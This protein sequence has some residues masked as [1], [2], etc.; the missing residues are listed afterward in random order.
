MC[1]QGLGFNLDGDPN[2]PMNPTGVTETALPVG[3]TYRMLT[4][5]WGDDVVALGLPLSP[6]VAQ[7]TTLGVFPGPE[8]GPGFS[9][10]ATFLE[11][12]QYERVISPDAPFDGIFPPEVSTVQIT[13]VVA[14]PEQDVVD[15]IDVTSEIPGAGPTIPTFD[16]TRVQR[17]DEWT[18]YL[19]DTTTK[20][21]L[22][23]VRSLSGT[24]ANVVLATN[25]TG[26][27]PMIDALTN[28]E[29][30]LAPPVGAPIPTSVF[31]P[32]GQELPAQLTYPPLPQPVTLTGNIV[33][34]D[35]TPIAADLVFEAL[36]ITDQNGLN[37]A[38]FEFVGAASARPTMSGASAYSVVLPP[39]QYRVDLRPAGGTGAVTVTSLLVGPSATSTTQ[40]FTV[41]A[42]RPLEGLARVAD[43][44]LLSGAIVEAVGTQC[45]TPAALADG[46]ATALLSVQAS[47]WCLPQSSQTTTAADGSFRLQLDPGSYLV[48]V[49]P[50]D[51]TRLPW[52]SKT[53]SVAGTAPGVTFTVPAPLSASVQLLDPA[54]IPIVNAV[55]RA[56]AVPSPSSSV[57]SPPAPA[58]EVGRAITDSTGTYEMY[59]SL[60]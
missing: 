5:F 7:P 45:F 44:R 12:A 52:V 10:Q 54:D 24:T 60:P 19:R 41:E 11:P 42:P 53:V 22:S 37:N 35:G 57:S 15:S 8:G 25:H 32:A 26:H 16:I 30:V 33:S 14:R 46:G 31:I 40:D 4:D 39:G 23:N 51:G 1:A 49:R 18:A 9:F 47:T 55:V 34:V 56:F 36:A 6:V 2:D 48:R 50:A 13:A 58:L 38:N 29:L 28:A 27:N 59:L 43:G 3:A 20:Q 17:L 21:V